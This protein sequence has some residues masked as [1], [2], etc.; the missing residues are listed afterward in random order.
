M[1]RVAGVDGC[2]GGWVAVLLDT[3]KARAHRPEIRVCARFVEVLALPGNLTVVAVDV[4][5]GLLEKPQRGGRFCDQE[6]RHLLG[7]RASSVFSPPSRQG[8]QAEH[9]AE[10]RGQ[11]L[12]RQAFGILPKIREVDRL[13]TPRLQAKVYEAHPELAFRT[14]TGH[15]MRFNKKTAQGRRERLRAL[16]QARPG[17]LKRLSCRVASGLK[18]LPRRQVA[19]DDLL[20][21]AALAYTALRIAKKEAIRIP[22]YPPQD[23]KGLRME[24]WY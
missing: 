18:F 5:I 6:A 10:V 21:A 3:Q 14:L 7:R 16:E 8:L 13:M 4:P 19:P 11:G 9:Y 12:T 2:R 22:S 23:G 17:W 20:D 24:I 15:P 1:T